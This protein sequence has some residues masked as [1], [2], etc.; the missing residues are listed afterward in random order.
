MFIGKRLCCKGWISLFIC[1]PVLS[2]FPLPKQGLYRCKL[3]GR[4]GI[5]NAFEAFVRRKVLQYASNG[6]HF[7]LIYKVGGLQFATRN[8]LCNMVYNGLQRKATLFCNGFQ[9]HSAFIKSVTYGVCSFLWAS[10]LPLPCAFCRAVLH[11]LRR[12]LI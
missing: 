5:F 7:L 1:F 10:F 9:V 4:A 11:R 12:P 6:C 3:F 8:I 2:F